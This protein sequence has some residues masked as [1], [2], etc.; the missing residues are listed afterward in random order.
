M[1][2][3]TMCVVIVVIT[4]GIVAVLYRTLQ[5]N[6]YL[7]EDILAVYQPRA[8]YGEITIEYPL[9]ETL[10]PPEMVPPEFHWKDRISASKAW[11]VRIEFADD[12]QLMHFP[13][14]RQR[15]TP[16]PEDW[17][18]IKH[19]SLERQTQVVILGID[20]GEP[21][22][23]LSQGRMS[24]RTSKDRVEAP[25][26]YREVALPFLDADKDLPGIRWRFGSI[27]SPKPPPVV[28]KNLPVCGNCHSFSR[29]GKTLA[30][31]VDY[32]NRKGSYVITTVREQMVLASK[33]II[34]WAD[35]EN[36]EQTYGLLS[37]ISPDGR[38]AI[39]TVK[40][41]SIFVPK[42][43]LAFSQEFFPVKGILCVFDRETGRFRELPG[44]DNPEFVQS[45]PIWSPDGEYIVFAR[46][47]APDLRNTKHQGHVWLTPAE[48][49]DFIAADEPFQFDL[50]RIPFNAGQGGTAEPVEGASHNGMSNYFARYS[51]DGR[52][53]VFCR[54]KSYML[55]QPDSE[56]YIIPAEGGNARR[57][58]CNTSRMNSWHSFSPNGKWLVFASKAYSDYTQLCLTH[59]DE[60]GYSTPAVLLAHM[61]AKNR[62]A[63]IPEFVNTHP[64]AIINIQKQFLRD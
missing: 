17:D 31:D 25:L 40:D 10:F 35:Q 55:L 5:P 50:Y 12:N 28:L 23:V 33:D 36:A 39:S 41:M 60:N 59:I 21:A 61:T 18:K 57:L 64:G 9:N 45:N 37:Q 56:L 13:V 63:N 19:R 47:K 4:L 51:P 29:D 53:I 44:A 6:T 30:M 26:F 49:R 42:K 38:Y 58:R 15:W 2:K 34:T 54:A 1:R 11:L 52:W 14:R 48:S 20:P 16:R 32:A 8:D 43:D 3:K 24:F 46:A 7:V 22:T 62:A 27:A